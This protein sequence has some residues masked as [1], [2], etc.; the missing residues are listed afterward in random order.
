[1]KPDVIT[2]KH[3]RIFNITIAAVVVIA[4]LMYAYGAFVPSPIAGKQDAV[5]EG[6]RMS[7]A[8]LKSAKDGVVADEAKIKDAEQLVVTECSKAQ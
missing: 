2:P 5:C 7:L 4:I 8:D 1:M 6:A 3:K